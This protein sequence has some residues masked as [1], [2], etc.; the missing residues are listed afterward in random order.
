MV[1]EIPDA[2]PLTNRTD[3]YTES[4]DRDESN[5]VLS[6]N[7]NADVNQMPRVFHT[8]QSFRAVVLLPVPRYPAR[9]AHL[10]GCFRDT[11]L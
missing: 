10:D 1:L 11:R 9:H 3:R 7:V 6:C 8:D 5:S 2:M 4:F